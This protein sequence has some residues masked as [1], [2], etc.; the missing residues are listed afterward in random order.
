VPKELLLFDLIL[1]YVIETNVV[2][3]CPVPNK[4]DL[5]PLLFLRKLDHREYRRVTPDHGPQALDRLGLPVAVLELGQGLRALD[6]DLA[7]VLQDVLAY[8]V[9]LLE[10]IFDQV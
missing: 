1:A 5:I 10:D 2:V 4:H 6:E 9:L 8:F 7:R 3:R